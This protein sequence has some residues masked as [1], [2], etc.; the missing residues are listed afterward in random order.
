MRL[1][2][3][4]L[5][6]CIENKPCPVVM[7]VLFLL[8][9]SRAHGLEHENDSAG[10]TEAHYIEGGQVIMPLDSQTLPRLLKEA[11]WNPPDTFKALIVRIEPYGK[12]G[13]AY[14]PYDYAGTSKDRE[15]WWPASCVKLYAAV[16]ALQRTRALG[17]SPEAELT[18]HYEDGP[19]T[20]KI[21]KLVRM[22]IIPSNNVAF[23]QL[24][25]FVGFDRLNRHFLTQRNGLGRTVMLRAYTFR[26]K[27][28]DTGRGCNRHSSRI[29]ITEGKKRGTIPRR[30]GRGEYDCPDQGNCTTLMEL[31]EALR[32]VMM[33]EHLPEE[34][35]YKLGRR[36]LRV[37]R[38][39]LSKRKKR[40]GGVVKGLMDAFSDRQ[41]KIYHKGGYSYEWF[42]DNVFL[43][44][45]DT[46][47]RWMLA[48]ANHPGREAL[49]EAV[50]HIARIIRD[51]VL[52]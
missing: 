9:M 22:A 29:T 23:D 12:G 46:D 43:H 20:R 36:E 10:K 38:N 48:M 49:D 28:P 26:D 52:R 44:F 5:L 15:N 17:F 37:L 18:F 19:V 13:F 16:A 24:V 45:T 33:H 34:E 27:Y 14:F 41:L 31:S 25:E 47:E 40:E 2:K 50:V 7:S 1:V 8:S 6:A 42:S 3:A 4:A 51:H 11:G 32:R 35:R 39:A 30:T 21:L